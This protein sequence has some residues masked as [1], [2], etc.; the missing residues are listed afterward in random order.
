MHYFFAVV[1]V[2]LVYAYLRMMC[3]DELCQEAAAISVLD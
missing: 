1:E 3:E 2:T